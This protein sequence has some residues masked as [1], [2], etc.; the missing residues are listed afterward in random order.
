MFWGPGLIG[1]AYFTTSL[2][3]FT[4]VTFW[5]VL[6]HS[7]LII[8][9]IYYKDLYFKIR[10]KYV[11]AFSN[12]YRLKMFSFKYFIIEFTFSPS[13]RYYYV[14]CVSLL[15]SDFIAQ[16]EINGSSWK[17]SLVYP[18]L[19]Y[20]WFLCDWTEHMLY[21]RAMYLY[22]LIRPWDQLAAPS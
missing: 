18:T 20:I 19:L 17:P 21:Q 9:I 13:L 1:G 2:L 16:V 14:I 12:I 3:D 7:Y 4:I 11:T 8:F 22:S 10:V 5:I 15:F 6:F